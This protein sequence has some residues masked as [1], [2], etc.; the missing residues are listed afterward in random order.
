MGTAWRDYYE[1]RWFLFTGAR[2]R[3]LFYLPTSKFMTLQDNATFIFRFSVLLNFCLL[4]YSYILDTLGKVTVSMLG[5]P[6]RFSH[7]ETKIHSFTRV[8]WHILQTDSFLLSKS[9]SNTMHLRIKIKDKVLPWTG[10]EGPE[11]EQR[12]S[13]TISLNSALDEGGW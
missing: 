6:P 5:A 1:L 3:G 11:W 2:G 13:S 10:H 4:T 8:T 12:Y 9:C 7:H